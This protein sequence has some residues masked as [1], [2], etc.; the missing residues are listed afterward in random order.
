MC[1]V[2]P[3]HDRGPG[4]VCDC[5]DISCVYVYDVRQSQHVPASLTR[6]ESTGRDAKW[7]HI[8]HHEGPAQVCPSPTSLLRL[9]IR[10]AIVNPPHAGASRRLSSSLSSMPPRHASKTPPFLPSPS[11]SESE[12]LSHGNKNWD[13]TSPEVISATSSSDSSS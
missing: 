7:G 6:R 5:L 12:P 13:T 2:G 8:A 10:R 9:D 1:V 11:P 4:Q 3:H